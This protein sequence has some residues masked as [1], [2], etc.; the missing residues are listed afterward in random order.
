[1]IELGELEKHHQEFAQRKV[2]LVVISNDD[3]S[4]SQA[5]QTDFQNLIVVSDSEQSMAKALQVLHT[6][7]G[8]TGEDTNVPTTFLVDGA[9]QVRWL[10]RP[11]R[12]IV[13]L[14]P[15]ELLTAVDEHLPGH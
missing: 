4:T 12:F 1:M 10:F 3:Q 14:S 13:R 11:T 2:R 5:T 15:Q 8:P 7:M 9:G 6:G